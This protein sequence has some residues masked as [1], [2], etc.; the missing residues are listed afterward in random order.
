MVAILAALNERS[1]RITFA[2]DDDRFNL[3]AQSCSFSAFW[4]SERSSGQEEVVDCSWPS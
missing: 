3:R 1:P 2:A 4:I